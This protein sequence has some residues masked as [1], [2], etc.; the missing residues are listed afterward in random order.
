MHEN[1][2]YAA[3]KVLEWETGSTW[4]ADHVLEKRKQGVV[5][6]VAKVSFKAGIGSR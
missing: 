1:R 3:L 4:R 6:E 2:R 5:A